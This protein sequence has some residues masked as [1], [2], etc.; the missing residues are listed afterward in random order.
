MEFLVR[1][2]HVDRYFD[3]I[4]FMYDH[5]ELMNKFEF[6]DMTREE[7][8]KDLMRRS[9]IAYKYGREKWFHNH[10][11]HIVHWAYVQNGL[12]PTQLTYT[13]FL[14]SCQAMM[15]DEQ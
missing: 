5:P 10:E 7:Q 1:E 9:N 12:S 15:N 13:M 2:S 3:A 6:Y 4:Q 14:N 11:P 8:Q